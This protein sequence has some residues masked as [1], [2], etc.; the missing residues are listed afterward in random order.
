LQ[1]RP[2]AKIVFS[3]IVVRTP[4]ILDIFHP[5][6]RMSN[7]RLSPV[8]YIC[9][10]SKLFWPLEKCRPTPRDGHGDGNE[11]GM[12]SFEAFKCTYTAF[13]ALVLYKKLLVI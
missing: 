3:P 2:I 6:G 4:Q 9:S 13:L 11:N 10:E 12:V 5:D 7:A 1:S 8:L